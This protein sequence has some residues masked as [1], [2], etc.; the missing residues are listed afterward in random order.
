MKKIFKLSLILFTI[1]VLYNCKKENDI[2][3]NNTTQDHSYVSKMPQKDQVEY[4]NK[5]LKQLGLV[6]NRLW[7]QKT[8]RMAIAKKLDKRVDN[9]FEPEFLFKDLPNLLYNSNNI[10]YSE[11]DIIKIK[12]ELDAF[13][14]ILKD[15]PINPQV[16]IPFYKKYKNKLLSVNNKSSQPE[17]RYVFATV[18]NEPN[19]VKSYKIINDVYEEQPGLL[20]EQDASQVPD[21]IVLGINEFN[22]DDYPDYH[23]VIVTDTLTVE[24][25]NAGVTPISNQDYAY[26]GD[27]YI[28]R[29]KITKHKESWY[30]GE[31]EVHYT[32]Y[33][34]TG[35]KNGG[36]QILINPTRI[37]NEYYQESIAVTGSSGPSGHLAAN[38]TRSEVSNNVIKSVHKKIVNDFV[39]VNSLPS[40]PSQ[41]LF[42]DE[43]YG[44]PYYGSRKYES[45]QV[46]VFEY[47]PWP[48]SS[49]NANLVFSLKTILDHSIHYANYT[50]HYRSSNSPYGHYMVFNVPYTIFNEVQPHF[51]NPNDTDEVIDT[52]PNHRSG[53]P[54]I[55]HAT[56]FNQ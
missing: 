35:D 12:K 34:L 38:W 47:D 40:P 53:M 45:V 20:N 2:E 8:F 28:D 37:L 48:A 27:L 25:V 18:P 44:G 41:Y 23:P 30:R 56:Y 42:E 26:K 39:G 19:E 55:K 43:I 9:N 21:L 32:A 10:K 5:H 3:T 49:N 1:F 33:G 11:N 6:F 13:N 31:S 4:A 50:F 24:N 51:Y 16:F 17:T 14:G 36:V 29:I 54:Y 52:W 7:K 15:E 22:P 46:V